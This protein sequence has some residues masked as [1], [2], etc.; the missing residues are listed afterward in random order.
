MKEI[1][2]KSARGYGTMIY[3]KKLKDRH[4]FA[5]TCVKEGLSQEEWILSKLNK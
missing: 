4:K 3:F 2:K 1:Y 5:I